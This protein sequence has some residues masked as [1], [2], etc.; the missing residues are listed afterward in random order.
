MGAKNLTGKGR[1]IVL[2]ADSGADENSL[3]EP[4]KVSPKTEPVEFN[5]TTITRTFPGNSFTVLRLG[6]KAD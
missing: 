6:I 2:R 5:G 3:A 1:A 4:M